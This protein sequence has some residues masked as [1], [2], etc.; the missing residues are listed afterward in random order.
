MAQL[1]A[2]SSRYRE[3]QRGLDFRA[4]MICSVIAE[5]NRDRKRRPKPFTPDDFLPKEESEELDNPKMKRAM[6]RINQM[7]GG[8]ER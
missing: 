1:G 6:K 4:A 3:E 2:L 8:E 5:V 7:L